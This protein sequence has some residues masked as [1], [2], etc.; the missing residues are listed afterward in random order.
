MVHTHGTQ[1]RRR[2]ARPEN[3]EQRS[4]TVL[5]QRS[6]TRTEH[7]NAT[8]EMAEVW[9]KIEGA[10]RCQMM[11][12]AVGKCRRPWNESTAPVSG[13]LRIAE[14][15]IR[16]EEV[17]VCARVR[18]RFVRHIVDVIAAARLKL[19]RVDRRSDPLTAAPPTS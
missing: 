17:D 3:R 11:L 2:Q 8:K 10:S 5:S 15:A 19:A 14:Q 12:V 16:R 7:P 13:L 9:P 4:E 6:E 18:E 1:R